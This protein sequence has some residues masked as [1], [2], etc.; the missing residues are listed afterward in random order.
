MEGV[1]PRRSSEVESI[2]GHFTALAKQDKVVGAVPVVHHIQTFLDFAPQ[3]RQAQ[4]AAQENS[5]AGFAQLRQGLISGMLKVIAGK[6]AQDG[7]GIGGAFA[8]SRSEFDEFIV[9]LADQV[10]ANGI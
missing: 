3:F 7:F 4:I 5:T 1:I 10:P 6:A 9:L 2:A 8:Q